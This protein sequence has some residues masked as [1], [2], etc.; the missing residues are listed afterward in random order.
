MYVVQHVRGTLGTQRQ[1]SWSDHSLNLLPLQAQRLEELSL[2]LGK[3]PV[4]MVVNDF[5]CLWTI[6]GLCYAIG[7][8]NV[9][10]KLSDLL[11]YVI[12]EMLGAEEK[13][14]DNHSD[15]I[16]DLLVLP[17]EDSEV[18]QCFMIAQQTR[19]SYPKT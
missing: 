6:E 17:V 12:L 9:G 2:W 3:G 7:H 1:H 18:K 13:L 8:L 11:G 5:H 16:P 4:Q 14:K 19:L 10:R 15:N